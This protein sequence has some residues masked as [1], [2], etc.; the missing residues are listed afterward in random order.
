[1]DG[2]GSNGDT[3]GRLVQDWLMKEPS[4]D[5]AIERF[6][7]HQRHHHLS[8][9]FLDLEMEM[10]TNPIY[11]GLGE[12]WL[13]FANGFDMDGVGERLKT[14]TETVRSKDGLAE[15]LSTRAN[16]KP[17]RDQTHN[18]LII[19]GQWTQDEDR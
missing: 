2:G 8:N 7:R 15:S 4:L 18:G 14:T 12:T 3:H 11:D 13:G 6:I 17:K 5:T 1:M 19:K 10:E 9:Q 16:R